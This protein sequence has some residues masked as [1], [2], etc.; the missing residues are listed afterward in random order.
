MGGRLTGWI[1]TPKEQLK[2]IKFVEFSDLP[3]LKNRSADKKLVLPYKSVRKFCE[4]AFEDDPQKTGDCTS[5]GTRNAAD[6]SRAVEI[7][8]DG[9]PEAWVARGATEAIYGYR[10][11]SDSGMN[12]GRATEFCTK[13]GLLL[14]KK[15]NFADLT[16][17]NVNVGIKW[18]KSGPPKEVLDEAQ[19]HPCLYFAKIRNLEQSKDALASGYGIHC[20][21]G[22][23]NNGKRNAKGISPWNDSWNHDMCWGGYEEDD[24]LNMLVL[25]S[26][27]VWNEGGQPDW[28]P[29]PGGSFLV[30]SKDA[31][32]MIDE[33]ECWAIGNV[34]GWP[35]Q[36]L[37]DYGSS[38]YL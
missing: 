14:R 1:P 18:G 28:G 32:R 29:I 12:P 38:S 20:G 23:G 30:P 34:R 10:G 13:Y 17:Y 33:G 15:Y 27:G 26:W 8:I 24:D 3:H 11:H 4:D 22:Y 9:E 35:A 19:K 6:I 25:N 31:R 21:S 37:P 5:H 2:R 16:M 36:D 7:D